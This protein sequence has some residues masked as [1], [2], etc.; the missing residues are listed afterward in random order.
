MGLLPY[1][2]G[3]GLRKKLQLMFCV[4]VKLWWHS[5]HMD[6]SSP[7]LHPEDVRSLGLGAIWSFIKGT[8]LPWLVHHIKGH[9]GPV[10]N[11]F[12]HQDWKGL[13]PFT[14]LFYSILFC[15]ICTF[16]L[17]SDINMYTN[18]IEDI[19]YCL[20][21]SKGWTERSGSWS[22]SCL[23]KI[24]YNYNDQHFVIIIIIIIMLNGYHWERTKDILKKT[25]NVHIT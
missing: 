11:A 18:I 4:S 2:G 21:Y 22:Y 17:H 16:I 13:N 9:K 5:R 10:K 20:S 23:R 3:V 12:V 1:V 7:F 6:L 19:V 24:S 25:D 14:T 15:S 8:G